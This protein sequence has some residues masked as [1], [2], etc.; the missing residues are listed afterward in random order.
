MHF[1][2][3]TGGSGKSVRGIAL[4]KASFGLWQAQAGQSRP[5]QWPR[6]VPSRLPLAFWVVRWYVIGRAG[7]HIENSG[8]G[9]AKWIPPLDV[10]DVRVDWAEDLWSHTSKSGEPIYMPNGS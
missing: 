7:A 1:G 2:G 5:V 10:F 8:S 3:N 4:K 9:G 6:Q